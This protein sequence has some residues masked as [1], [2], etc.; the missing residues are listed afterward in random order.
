MESLISSAPGDE[1][2]RREAAAAEAR[3]DPADVSQTNVWE[4]KCHLVRIKVPLS[5][6]S[7]LHERLIPSRL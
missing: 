6:A 2:R 4:L 5:A 3:D 7:R 1:W